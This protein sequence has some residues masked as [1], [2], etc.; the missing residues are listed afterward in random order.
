MS[1]ESSKY[2]W[3]WSRRF[4][5]VGINDP[6]VLVSL[7]HRGDMH[8]RVQAD[9]VGHQSGRKRNLSPLHLTAFKPTRKASRIAI[10]VTLQSLRP[11]CPFLTL[12]SNLRKENGAQYRSQREQ[13]QTKECILLP[14]HLPAGGPC[15]H[16]VLSAPH[17]AMS[18]GFMPSLETQVPAP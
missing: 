9:K 18:P 2:K 13:K 3:E 10:A 15:P 14:R 4:L 7:L 11:S 17:S 12:T 8:A 6:F 16:P 5:F 1:Q